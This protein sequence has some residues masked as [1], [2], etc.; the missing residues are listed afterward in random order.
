MKFIRNYE[1]MNSYYNGTYFTDPLLIEYRVFER[2][3][4]SGSNNHVVFINEVSLKHCHV[5][6]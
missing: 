5:D 6:G 4:L 2:S 3:C 1:L